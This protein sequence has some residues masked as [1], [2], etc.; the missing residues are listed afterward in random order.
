MLEFFGRIMRRREGIAANP[1]YKLAVDVAA[2][3]ILYT[4]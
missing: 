1:I 2:A 3:K 4:H